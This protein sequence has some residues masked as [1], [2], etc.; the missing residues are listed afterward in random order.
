MELK[1]KRT[2]NKNYITLTFAVLLALLLGC[3][4]G[5]KTTG[6]KKDDDNSWRGV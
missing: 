6:I 2:M 5:E 4:T 1:D 3:T